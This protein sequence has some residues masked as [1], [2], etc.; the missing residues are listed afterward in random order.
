MKNCVKC[1]KEIGTQDNY[2]QHCGSNQ[3]RDELMDRLEKVESSINSTVKKENT[4]LLVTLS[5]LS[6]IGSVFGIGRGLL[7][8]AVSSLDADSEY[9][10]GY[11]YVYANLGSL[12]GII[13]VLSKK[14][15]GL[16]IYS[17]SQVVYIVTVIWAAMSYEVESSFAV[18]LS[19]F[20]LLP[21]AVFV[22]LFW[23]KD[24][25]NKLS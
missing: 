13:M 2:C 15:W 22:F 18:A 5:V 11:I 7:Y 16:Y 12:I 25:K 17:I 8:E 3:L 4:G 9:I 24:I 19:S 6:I 21:S 1:Q 23:S 14:I 20:F 10:R